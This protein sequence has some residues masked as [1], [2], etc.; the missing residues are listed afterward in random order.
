MQI[1]LWPGALP[2]AP[3]HPPTSGVGGPALCSVSERDS[4]EQPVIVWILF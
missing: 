4:H 1:P 3:A 2:D